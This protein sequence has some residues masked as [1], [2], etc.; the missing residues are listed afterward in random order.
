[1]ELAN[2]DSFTPLEVMNDNMVNTTST[3]VEVFHHV[4]LQEVMET[5][6]KSPTNS[7]ELDPMPTELIKDNIETISPLIQIIATNSFSESVFPDDLKEA[8]IRTILKKPDLKLVESNYCPVSNMTFLSKSLERQAAKRSMEHVQPMMEPH[9][10]AYHEDH[11]TETALLRVK[12]DIM[13]ASDKGKVVCLVLLDFSAAFDTVDDEVLLHRLEQDYSIT[14]TAI[15]WIHL[16]LSGR[17]QRVAIGDLGVD[18]VTS[19]LV[20]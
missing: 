5:I 17:R 10:S 12:T 2:D 14:D 20:T 3:K 11:S 1:M 15:K 19:D 8:L 9:Q 18:G 4:S 6:M 16:Y 7:C 13:K